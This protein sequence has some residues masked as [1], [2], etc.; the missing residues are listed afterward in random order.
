MTNDVLSYLATTS[1]KAGT[2]RKRRSFSMPRFRQ[3]S[4]HG[5]PLNRHQPPPRL[6]PNAVALTTPHMTPKG[7]IERYTRWIRPSDAEELMAALLKTH[8]RVNSG[9]EMMVKAQ[10]QSSD[11]PDSYI[12]DTSTAAKHYILSRRLH[13]EFFSPRQPRQSP[14]QRGVRDI[15]SLWSTSQWLR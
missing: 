9:T 4:A 11:I 3:R 5:H 14:R 7:R 12:L 10:M 15:P 1:N 6:S 2:H 13:S 8:G